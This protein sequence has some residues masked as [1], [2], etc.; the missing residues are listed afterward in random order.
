VNAD[1]AIFAPRA[2]TLV[3]SLPI[4]HAASVVRAGGVIAYPT[5]AVW[6]LGCDPWNAEAVYRLLE[7]KQRPA[8]KGLILVAAHI[9]QV[10]GLLD[11]LSPAQ[12]ARL[13]LSWPGPFTWLIPHQD[14]VPP[15]VTGKHSSVAVRVSAHPVVVALC[16]AFGGPLIS[17]SANIA[18]AQS[19]RERFQ[20]QRYFGDQVDC[21]VQGRTGGASRASL[22]RDLLTDQVVRA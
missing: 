21:Y 14:R 3:P 2:E 11:G 16:N 6:G 1:K 4:C 17:T 7:L 10:A 8:E 9:D 22:I 19:P 12:H 5:E 18:G 15:W 13:Q 20:V